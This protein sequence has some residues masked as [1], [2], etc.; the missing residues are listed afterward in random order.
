[1]G[2]LN[3]TFTSTELMGS[4]LSTYLKIARDREKELKRELTDAELKEIYIVMMAQHK[5]VTSI[6]LPKPWATIPVS[7]VESFIMLWLFSLLYWWAIDSI[8]DSIIK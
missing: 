7:I 8:K 1:M 4:L 3:P 6:P 5:T 2:T